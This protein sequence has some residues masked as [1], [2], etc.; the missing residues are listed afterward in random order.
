M[1]SVSTVNLIESFTQALAV[2]HIANQKYAVFLYSLEADTNNHIYS[3]KYK[4]HDITRDFG[5]K[6]NLP[7]PTKPNSELRVIFK[8]YREIIA[9]EFAPRVLCE[10]IDLEHRKITGRSNWQATQR[11]YWRDKIV[12]RHLYS[13]NNM[14]LVIFL[15]F[16]D[17]DEKYEQELFSMTIDPL[18][19][20]VEADEIQGIVFPKSFFSTIEGHLNKLPL[21]LGE[22]ANIL[23]HTYRDVDLMK[24]YKKFLFNNIIGIEDQIS[25]KQQQAL[26]ELANV[27]EIHQDKLFKI[28]FYRDHY[29]HQCNVYLLG[30]S[31]ISI[32][33]NEFGKK[34]HS[35]CNQAYRP[36]KRQ[37]YTDL[38]DVI[39]IWLLASLFHDISYP[40]EKFEPWLNAF[41]DQFVFIKKEYSKPIIK[42]KLEISNV[43]AD[44]DHNYYIEELSEY[45]R[46]KILVDSKINYENISKNIITKS[47]RIRNLIMNQTLQYYDHGILSA[48]MLLTRLD[49]D[50]ESY[51]YLYPATAAVSLHNFMWINKNYRDVPCKNCSQYICNECKEWHRIYDQYFKEW[52]ESFDKN[53]L[54][55]ENIECLRWIDFENDPITFLLVLCDLIQD[56]GRIDYNNITSANYSP[57]N[58]TTIE[59]ISVE[60]K[61]IIIDIRF[62]EFNADSTN[63]VDDFILNKK[64]EIAF[65]FSRLKFIDGYDIIIN[66][67]APDDTSTIFSM[68]TF[69]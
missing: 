3:M 50:K 64:K 55:E 20:R 63:T 69:I 26:L 2:R 22:N 66:L 67:I 29:L 44:L 49:V 39:S 14:Y 56:W 1:D 28:P 34:L 41:F 23:K 15:F 13:L 60:N 42:G 17:F 24:T 57:S 61:S 35:I 46:K 48:I 38:T 16:T 47:C 37:Q 62:N 33:E 51:R 12:Y 10:K 18:L 19:K 7:F 65:V 53:R 31:L 58:P 40:L 11:N 59:R 8:T 5:D 6:N 68:N 25:P 54:S 4:H 43:L 32:I 21:K 30:L 9:N 36:I 27:Y 52:N 45:L